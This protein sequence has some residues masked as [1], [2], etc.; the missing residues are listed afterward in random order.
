M[1]R[2][3]T[4]RSSARPP[5]CSTSVASPAR[6]RPRTSSSSES[7]LGR[8]SERRADR[9]TL[10]LAAVAVGTAG[11]VIGS[12]VLK[13]ARRR[14]KSEP[15]PDTVKGA[16]EQALGAAQLGTQDAVTVGV[17]GY[18]ATPRGET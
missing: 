1:A 11:T 13:L 4:S 8:G 9:L 14:A 5:L 3:T 2:S 16:A 10:G 18:E 7:M 15:A 17:V 6:S 12:E